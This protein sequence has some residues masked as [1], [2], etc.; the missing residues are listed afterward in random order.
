M[1]FVK[2][3]DA[4]MRIITFLGFILSIIFL[5]IGLFFLLY[6]LIF[7]ENFALGIA[8]LIILLCLISSFLLLSLGIIGEYIL[9][10][11]SFS[12]KL[13]LVSKK[14]EINFDN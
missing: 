9:V 7:W 8:P 2:M 12:R 6:K 5:F 3:S 1:G 4:P 11:L 13:P 14:K 10:L